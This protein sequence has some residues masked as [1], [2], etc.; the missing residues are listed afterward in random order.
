MTQI[1][2]RFIKISLKQVPK[3]ITFNKSS[4]VLVMVGCHQ[5]WQYISDGN[6]DFCCGSIFK[7][8]QI[9]IFTNAMDAELSVHEHKIYCTTLLPQHIPWKRQT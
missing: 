7:S 6:N 2:Q 9:F 3:V 1:P 8:Q 5:A 4:L